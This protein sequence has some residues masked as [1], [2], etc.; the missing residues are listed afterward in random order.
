ML[1]YTLYNGWH[2]STNANSINII[3]TFV[4]QVTLDK[5]FNFNNIKIGS[6]NIL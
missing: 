3:N 2:G 1:H 6:Y 5:K 4:T